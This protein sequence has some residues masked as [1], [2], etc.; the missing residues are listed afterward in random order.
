M[1]SIASASK[2]GTVYIVDDEKPIASLLESILLEAGYE[3]L[4]SYASEDALDE[5]RDFDGEIDLFILDVVL[6]ELSGPDLAQKL[7]TMFPDSAILFT[8]GYGQGAGAALRRSNPEATFLSKPFVVDEVQAAITE[9]LE[10]RPAA[11]R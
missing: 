1:V 8:S 3:V 4:V 2:K 7:E 10:G 9:A 6:P 11:A 5:L